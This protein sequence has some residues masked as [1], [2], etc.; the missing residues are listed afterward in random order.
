MK[1]LSVV[2]PAYNEQKNVSLLYNKLKEVLSSMKKTYEII[3]VDDGSTDSTFLELEN[4]QKKDLN[5]IVIKFRGNFGQTFALDAG[6]KAA[7]GKVI[8]SMDADLQND[9]ADI[10]IL[11]TKMKEGYDVVCG[12]RRDRK[13]P[14]LKHIISRGAYLLRKILF[15][16]EVHDSGCTLKAFKRECF[17]DLDL[18]GE[19]HRFIPALLSWQGFKITEVAVRHHK[20]KYGETKYTIKRVLKGFLDMIVVKFW[21]RY[22]SRPIYL[23]GGFGLLMTIVGLVIGFYLSVQKILHYDSY[24]LSDRPLLLFSVLLVILGV[25]FVVSGLLADIIIKTYYKKGKPYKP[26]K[27][28]RELK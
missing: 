9:P 2:I 11:L 17:N 6:F 14:L 7:R 19:M 13:D 10:P 4:I 24:T 12:W 22:S 1:E 27:I 5:V 16:D 8:I 28:E 26:Y 23:F 15:K 21:M 3:F 25:Q 18:F 20:R